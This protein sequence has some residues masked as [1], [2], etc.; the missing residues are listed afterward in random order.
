MWSDQY[1]GFL[2][3]LLCHQ[4]GRDALAKVDPTGVPH[5][6][7]RTALAESAGGNGSVPDSLRDTV[8]LFLRENGVEVDPRKST[9]DAAAEH[10][11]TLAA[12][13][14]RNGP[15]RSQAKSLISELY[16]ATRYLPGWPSERVAYLV[17]SLSELQET[18]AK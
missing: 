5:R 18:I 4:Q 6:G 3:G 11:A 1:I 2:M 13:E 17:R 12:R 14:K 9:L 7:L 10:A 15:L 8:R 16:E